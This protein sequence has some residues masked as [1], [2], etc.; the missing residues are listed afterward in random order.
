MAGDVTGAAA[1]ARRIAD[2]TARQEVQPRIQRTGALAVEAAAPIQDVVTARLVTERVVGQERIG[3]ER[4]AV[5]D[6]ALPG[7]GA[8]GA[9]G[10]PGAGVAA[11]AAVVAEGRVAGRVALEGRVG[12]DEDEAD[13]GAEPPGDE[14][15]GAPDGAEPADA[16]GLVEVEDDVGGGLPGATG[17]AWMSS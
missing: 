12:D 6:G 10:V 4:A 16:G 5:G 1:Q 3:A 2:G 17:S 14:M 9:D 11:G 8:V 7:V 15:S 13:E